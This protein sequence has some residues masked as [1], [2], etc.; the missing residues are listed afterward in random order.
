MNAQRDPRT[1]KLRLPQRRRSRNGY[2]DPWQAADGDKS[3]EQGLWLISY[4]D[5]MT[6][7]FSFFVLLFAHERAATLV[8]ARPAKV[9]VAQAQPVAAKPAKAKTPA[10]VPPPAAKPAPVVVPPA[11]EI[12]LAPPMLAPPPVTVMAPSLSLIPEA[13]ASEQTAEQLTALLARETANEQVDIVRAEDSV[14]VEVSDDILFDPGSVALRG[15]GLR[16]LGRLAPVLA[17]QEGAIEVEGHTD[18]VPIANS[19]FPSNW[20]L[21][22]A[23][24]TAVTRFLTAQGVP[25]GKLRAVG[26]A[27]NQPRADNATPEG[28]AKNR[29]VSVVARLGSYR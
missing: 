24:A 6:L 9:Q 29:R 21:S 14:R 5:V 22:A 26:M 11:P 12:A 15:E 4:L 25:A 1:G 20:E 28:R 17:K 13:A 10:P 2:P 18:N 7:L 19:L 16:M 8:E 23:R 27:D 3:G